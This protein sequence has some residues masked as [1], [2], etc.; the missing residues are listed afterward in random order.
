VFCFVD[1]A[2]YVC[3]KY[4]SILRREYSVQFHA[5]MKQLRG[6]CASAGIAVWCSA[7][8]FYPAEICAFL[9]YHAAS[10]ANP[11][12]TFRDNVLVPSSR[13]KSS[14]NVNIAAEA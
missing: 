11:L 4:Y 10:S 5:I 1:N 3:L 12:P 13:V 7:G 9:G 6:G 8:K 14:K 2:S